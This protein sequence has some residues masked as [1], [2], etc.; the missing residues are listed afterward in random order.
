M[1]MMKNVSSNARGETVFTALEV[2]KIKKYAI[3][4]TYNLAVVV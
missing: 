2:W 3:I 1:L 4:K